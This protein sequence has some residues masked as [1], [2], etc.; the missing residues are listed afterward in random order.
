[1]LVEGEKCACELR[2][3]TGL[4]VTTSSHGA[5]CADKTDWTP[6]AGRNVVILPDND[7]DGML[8]AE[9]VSTILL[10]L[11]ATVKTIKLPGLPPKGDCVE[12]LQRAKRP[13]A[14]RHCERATSACQG[15]RDP[16]RHIGRGRNPRG[17][18]KS[19]CLQR[20]RWRQR[21]DVR[22]PVQRNHPLHSCSRIVVHLGW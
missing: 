19:R 14:R 22:R 17:D 7:S 6:L 12:W 9:K 2:E 3:R 11:Q 13:V 15:F 1:M 18:E 21:R 5:K 20:K 16:C 8:Y 10:G 4:L